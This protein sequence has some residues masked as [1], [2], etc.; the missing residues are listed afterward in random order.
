MNTYEQNKLKR[1]QKLKK[2]FDE[3]YKD[4]KKRL[5]E[6]WRILSREFFISSTQIQRRLRDYDS[7]YL[8]EE[9][10]EPKIV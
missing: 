2:R 8:N 4:Q 3:L 1:D 10:N 9:E 5:D 7:Q 6:V